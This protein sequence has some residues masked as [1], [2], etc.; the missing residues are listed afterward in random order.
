VFCIYDIP[1]GLCCSATLPIIVI[2]AV[3]KAELVLRA[4]NLVVHMRARI[5]VGPN[6]VIFIETAETVFGGLLEARAPGK[7]GKGQPGKRV[8]GMRR[9]RTTQRGEACRRFKFV[10]S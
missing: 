7:P 6:G 10:G 1:I 8:R 3:E 9:E 4:V 5:V 2:A